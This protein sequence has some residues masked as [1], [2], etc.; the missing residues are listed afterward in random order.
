MA[1]LR[2][3]GVI[4]SGNLAG[5]YAESLV[6]RAFGADLKGS[7]CKGFDL[8]AP[9]VGRVQV[10]ARIVGTPILP[11]QR[12]LSAFRSF[13]TFD[14]LVAVFL[15]DDALEVVQATAWPVAYVEAHSR[16]K[17][18]DNSRVFIASP[19]AIADPCAVDL[20]DALRAAA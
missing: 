19:G 2:A 16:P 7:S 14:S 10:K 5:D 1:T 17:A 13:D 12:Q 8:E 4:R 15:S 6:A 3:R 20:T 9:G 18:L 11:G